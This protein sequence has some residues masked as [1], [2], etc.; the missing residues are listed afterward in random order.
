MEYLEGE[1]LAQR[2][3]KGALLLDQALQVAIQIA[4]ALDVTGAPVPVLD[5]LQVGGLFDERQFSVSANG[6]RVYLRADGGTGSSVLQGGPEYIGTIRS[7]K[8]GRIH[9]HSTHSAIPA[10]AAVRVGCSWSPTGY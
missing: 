6:S 10:G 8:Y 3:Q 9:V 1:T 4:D 2:L 5:T 7:N